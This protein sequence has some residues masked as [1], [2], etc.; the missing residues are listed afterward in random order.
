MMIPKNKKSLI[1][2]LTYEKLE[3]LELLDIWIQ[4]GGN[5]D[6]LIEEGFL[7]I[8]DIE[9]E[10]EDITQEQPKSSLKIG[11][12]LVFVLALLSI[13]ICFQA[14]QIIQTVREIA[15]ISAHQIMKNP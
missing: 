12:M 14:N 5:I 7:N 9:E 15:R 2:N 11:I 6:Y 4:T 8:T 1:N 10:N 13:G 3:N